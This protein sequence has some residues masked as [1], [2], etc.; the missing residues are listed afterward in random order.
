MASVGTDSRI[1]GEGGQT[2]VNTTGTECPLKKPTWCSVETELHSTR[3][4][5]QRHLYPSG[6]EAILPWLEPQLEP[7]RQPLDIAYIFTTAATT[8]SDATA[9]MKPASTSPTMV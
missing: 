6:A 1:G 2:A 3:T 4:H 9:T 5:D 8:T 7:H